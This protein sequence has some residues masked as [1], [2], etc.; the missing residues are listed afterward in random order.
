[1]ETTDRRVRRTHRSL[2][3]ALMSLVLEKRY[4]SITVQDILDRS[5]IGRS[6]FYAHFSDKDALF[7]SGTNGL[8][9]TLEAALQ[10][11][12]PTATGHKIVIGFSRALFEHAH[13][14][15][16]LYYALLST[17]AWP[18]FRNRLQDI[19][20]ELIRRECKA[21][22]QKVKKANSDV[23][24][25]LVVHYLAAALLSVLTWWLDRKSR[26]TPSQI[27]DVFCSLVLPTIDAVLK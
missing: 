20:Q 1:M 3:K 2:H 8:R 13:E 9:E 16:N 21:E 26:L 7:L 22:I 19:L 6:T 15:R 11:A 24:V 27:D 12:R 4:D 14:Y 17:Q 5:D 10:R 23:P 25:D 18:L